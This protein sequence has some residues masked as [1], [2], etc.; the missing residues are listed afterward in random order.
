MKRTLAFC[1]VVAL[2]VPA[3]ALA[4]NE[5]HPEDEFQLKTWLPIHLGPL[6]LSVNKA[7]AYLWLGA[8]LTMALGILLMRL[9]LRHDPDRRQ[10]VGETIYDLVET[11]IAEQGL[12]AKAIGIWFPYVAS[13][14]LY[15]WILNL[16]GF[17][18]L[19]LTNEKFHIAGVALPTWGIYAATA[20]LSVT[21]TL[22]ILSVVFTHI[23][24]FRFNGPGYPKSFVPTG[25]PRLMI[26]FM[27]MLETI[28]HGFRVISLSVR[29]YANMLA[30]HML[31]L[32][33]IGLTFVLGTI[34]FVPISLVFA[35][36][37]YLFEVMIVVTI[38]AF[39]F[40]ALSAIYIGSAIEPDH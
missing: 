10:T 34:F 28:S 35:S 7:V 3:P 25:V 31:I 38:Q 36:V 37:F 12:P 40:A 39:I 17:V 30:G 29:L 19:P 16:V 8:L 4:I 14:F 2:A 24:G 23:E 5:Y 15:I 20:Q 1:A 22:A 27:A 9:R 18:P 6:D 26:P 13:L 33:F 32:L 21:L 11:Q